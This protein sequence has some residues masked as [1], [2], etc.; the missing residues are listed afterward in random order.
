MGNKRES[1]I[2][3]GIPTAILV[4]FFMGSLGG[5]MNIDRKWGEKEEKML[6]QGKYILEVR[7][8]DEFQEGCV[9]P[10]D[11]GVHYRDLDGNGKQ[12]SYLTV[13]GKDYLLRMDDGRPVLSD[14]RVTSPTLSR[15]VVEE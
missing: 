10:N 5:G 1:L 13:G 11:L 14:F 15:L 2:G 4:S 6:K 3:S 8:T 12:E 9:A 7:P